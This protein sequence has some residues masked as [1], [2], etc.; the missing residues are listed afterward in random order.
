MYKNKAW[1]QRLREDYNQ[2]MKDLDI[3]LNGDGIQYKHEVV[4]AI[5]RPSALKTSIHNVHPMLKD[6][7]G[8]IIGVD[9]RRNSKNTTIPINMR[10]MKIQTNT[11]QE[12]TNNAKSKPK[13][14]IN[15]L[16]TSSEPLALEVT[17]KLAAMT[18]KYYKKHLS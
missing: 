12:V 16:A 11:D 10:Y 6:A 13:Q 8:N 5:V 2:A 1:S 3:W 14:L 18:M 4:Y 9:Y 17:S 7:E 15:L